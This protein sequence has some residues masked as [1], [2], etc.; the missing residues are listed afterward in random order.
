M[1]FFAELHVAFAATRI[2]A[3]DL[4]APLDGFAPV[5][6]ELAELFGSAGRIV[7]GVKDEDDAL[8]AERGKRDLA[9]GI[10]GYGEV[11]GAGSHGERVGEEPGEHQGVVIRIGLL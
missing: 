9:A 1:V 7:A 10:V 4:D 11:G 5:L 8:A 6:P 3:E 2:D